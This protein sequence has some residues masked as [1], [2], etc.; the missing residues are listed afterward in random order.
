MI[1]SMRVRVLAVFGAMLA[2]VL[3]AEAGLAGAHA[4]SAPP[5]PIVAHTTVAI[6]ADNPSR[7]NS[8]K[9]IFAALRNNLPEAV[10]TVP[11]LNADPEIIR[12][13]AIVPGLNV[14]SAV[15]V[16]LHGDCT[17]YPQ[18]AHFP[19]GKALGWV[20][21]QKHEIQPYIHVDCTRIAQA[22][23]I[24]SEFMS[25]DQRTAA[26]SEAIARVVLHEWIHIAS[27]RSAHHQNGLGK[28][29]FTVEDLIPSTTSRT[30]ARNY[31]P[32]IP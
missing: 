13:D 18:P 27:Q 31:A 9:A 10:A 12:G 15:V 28:A 20:L 5:L 25:R 30:V 7:I 3:F 1:R 11:S 32:R 24:Q 22:L 26:I 21:E 23:S 2:A 6:F 17:L 19:Q 29:Q 4:Q 14:D 16:F 8:W